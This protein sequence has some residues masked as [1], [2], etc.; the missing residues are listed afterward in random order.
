MSKLFDKLME[1]KKKDGGKMRPEEKEAK[2]GVLENLKQAMTES[3]SGKLGGLKKV[4][5]ASDSTE[6]LKKGLDKA[7]EITGHLPESESE[8]DSESPAHEAAESVEEETAEHEAGSEESEDEE[9]TPEE[10]DAKIQKL[11][12]LKKKMK[13]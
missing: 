1:K 5:V 4:T 3:M 10:I 2:M 13:S 9:C 11:L 6:G 12:A 7:K 8:E